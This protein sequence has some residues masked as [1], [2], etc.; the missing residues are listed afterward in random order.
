MSATTGDKARFGRLQKKKVA[1]RLKTRAL[2]K[3][4]LASAQSKP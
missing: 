2:R 1:R 3:A 4:V